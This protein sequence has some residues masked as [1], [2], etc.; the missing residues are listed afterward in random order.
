MSRFRHKFTLPLILTLL[1]LAIASLLIGFFNLKRQ[2]TLPSN[3]NT[4]AIGVELNQDFNY[5]DLHQLQSNGISFIYLRSTQGKTYFD[6]DY[7]SYRDQ[8][9]GTNLA[10]GTIQSFSNESSVEQQFKFFEKKVGRNTGS[11]PVMIVPAVNTRQGRYLRSMAKFAN[12]LQKAGKKIIVKIDY[13]YHRYF[14]PQTQFLA[15]SRQQPDK[16]Q[17]A[18]WQYTENGRVKNVSGLERNVVMFSYNGSVTQYKQK[19][20]QLTQ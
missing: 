17:Y 9:Q 5:V 8:V 15:S 20:G 1:V 10:F 2:T 19:Y 3:S 11:L 4:S 13:Q 12:L 7:L 16:L 6:D 14:S 18:F